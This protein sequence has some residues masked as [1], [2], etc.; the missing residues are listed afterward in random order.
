[1]TTDAKPDLVRELQALVPIFSAAAVWGGFSLWLFS[2]GHAPSGPSIFPA[3]SHYAWQAV[4]LPI[5]MLFAFTGASKVARLAV[6]DAAPDRLRFRFL[7]G[8]ALS[9]PLEIAF[10][11]PDIVVFASQG[12]DALAPLLRI[13]GPILLVTSGLTTA[14]VL[15]R[16]GARSW[17]RATLFAVGSVAMFY[18]LL[19]LVIR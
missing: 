19:S 12:F 7:L 14:V 3:A 18:F 17:V 11:L 15:R 2:R 9:A 1:M 5:A 6:R 10:L 13:T 8:V 4:V 16:L